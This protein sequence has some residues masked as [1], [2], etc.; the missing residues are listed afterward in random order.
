MAGLA[1]YDRL[2][3]ALHLYTSIFLAPWMIMYAVT[4]SW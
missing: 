4:A 3:R 2:M 1:H